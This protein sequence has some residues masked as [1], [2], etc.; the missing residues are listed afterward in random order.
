MEKKL[1]G[2]LTISR[3]HRSGD[4]PDTIN[5]RFEDRTSSIEF[6]S[7]VVSLEGFAK[8]ITGLSFVEGE[9]TVNR[10]DAVGKK[11]E[12]KKDKRFIGEVE[13]N[14]VCDAVTYDKRSDALVGWLRK[15][16][17]EE[18]WEISGYLGSRGS[19][20]RDFDRGGWWLNFTRFRYVDVA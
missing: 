8:A 17:S 12:T 3:T 7:I 6:A 1:E 2:A 14:T 11:Y 5:I 16:H 9:L 4:G 15:Y 20:E 18:D 10:L 19:V 13:Y